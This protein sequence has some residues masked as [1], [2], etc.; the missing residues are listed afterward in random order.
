MRGIITVRTVNDDFPARHGYLNPELK[1]RTLLMVP[2]VGS[3]D[4]Y[5]TADD[6]TTEP[7]QAPRQLANTRIQR[8]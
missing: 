6:L 8:H 3:L 4:H 1:Q 7:F 5:L 2:M